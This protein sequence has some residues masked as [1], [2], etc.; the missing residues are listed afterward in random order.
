MG[1]ER[2]MDPQPAPSYQH[3]PTLDRQGIGKDGTVIEPADQAIREAGRGSDDEMVVQW[4]RAIQK[5]CKERGIRFTPARLRV[6][7]MLADAQ[8]PLKAYAILE[9]VRLENPSTAPTSIY[10]VLEFLQSQGWAVKLNSINAFLL[11]PPGPDWQCTFLVC[12]HCGS[13]ETIH[14]PALHSA[15]MAGPHIADFTPASKTLEI[16]G[17]CSTC[18]ARLQTMETASGPHRS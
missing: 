17:T 5:S 16:S 14:G 1:D 7:E 9:A 6:V 12:E 4:V 18:Q 13:V 11:R 3:E 15:L 2:A 8:R 10:R